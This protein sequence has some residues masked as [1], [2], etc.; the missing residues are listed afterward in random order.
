M[1]AY[2]L[3]G[4]QMPDVHLSSQVPWT[5]LKVLVSAGYF[6]EIEK[7][8]FESLPTRY[9]QDIEPIPLL[10][11]TAFVIRT[12]LRASGQNCIFGAEALPL[13]RALKELVKAPYSGPLHQQVFVCMIYSGNGKY[14]HVKCLKEN[15]LEVGRQKAKEFWDNGPY[16]SDEEF[17][18]PIRNINPNF[19]FHKKSK[20]DKK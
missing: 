10:L 16:S 18:R 2:H 3:L 9:K 12:Q 1:E 11:A 8:A 5:V 6:L 7:Q 15:F 4:H 17:E 19:D 13:P 20:K 14:D